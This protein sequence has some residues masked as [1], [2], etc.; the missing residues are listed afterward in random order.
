MSLEHRLAKELLAGWHLHFD[1]SWVLFEDRLLN[2][3]ILRG[4]PA[5]SEWAVLGSSRY[6]G[7][8]ARHFPGKTFFNHSLRRATL[9]DLV[10][11]WQSALEAGRAP[12]RLLVGVDG[13]LFD[14]RWWVSY[15]RVLQPEIARW[16]TRT[17]FRLAD[18]FF[19][20]QHGG[21][22]DFHGLGR[23]L[24]RAW[25]SA[26]V[27]WKI[28]GKVSRRRVDSGMAYVKR[29]DGSIRYHAGFRK[30]TSAEVENRILASATFPAHPVSREFSSLFGAWLQDI[31]KNRTSVCVL[32]HPYHPALFRLAGRIP[33]ATA[34]VDRLR[35]LEKSVKRVARSEG[36]RVVGSFDPE[37]FPGCREEMLDWMHSRPSLVPRLL[38]PLAV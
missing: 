13:W 25:L 10:G 7:I 22:E 33:S 3:E 16:A 4:L 37:R 29:P 18:R 12:R 27:A 5:P 9:P 14:S 35:I 20:A 31:R 26:A 38:R 2:R 21:P 36:V 8:R 30:Q 24:R 34:Y 1:P 6:L 15:A 17:R 32:L 11:L 23:R 19:P 28:L